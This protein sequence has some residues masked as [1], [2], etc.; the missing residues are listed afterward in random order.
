MT[1]P[2]SSEEL[3]ALRR[4]DTCTVSNTIDTF[5]VRLRNEGYTDSSIHCYTPK[6]VP[7]VGYAVTIRIRCSNPQPAGRAYLERMDWWQHLLS[8][9]EPRIVV[10]Q[11]MD[12]HVGTGAFP[13]EVHA[14]I[15]R[16]MGCVG[17]VT[18][19]CVHDLP[20]IEKM[21]FQLFA[22]GLTLSHAYAHIVGFGIPVEVGGLTI[23]P[24]DLLHADVHG[25]LNVPKSIAA[26]IPAKADRIIEREKR[27]FDLCDS[28]Q[29][30]LERLLSIVESPIE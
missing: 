12:A 26:Q 13:G 1:K 18:N 27:I 25:V 22:S 30:T 8:I 9:P 19:G 16:A 3:E 17:A 21:D 7:M 15:W 23:N 20:P 10:I 14:R 4:Y 6:P 28:D 11:D 5:G 24:G 2:L 29:F